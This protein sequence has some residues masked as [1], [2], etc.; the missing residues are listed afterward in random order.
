VYDG[1]GTTDIE[2]TQAAVNGARKQLRNGQLII[3]RDGKAFNAQGAV[4]KD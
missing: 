4:L 2:N 3:V 1:T